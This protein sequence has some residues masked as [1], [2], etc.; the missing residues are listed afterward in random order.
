MV[1]PLTTIRLFIIRNTSDDDANTT[2]T[3]IRIT[4][5]V[6][7]E[8]LRLVLL[9]MQD[10]TFLCRKVSYAITEMLILDLFK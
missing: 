2:Y 9:A 4:L 10:G 5:A 6:Q 7:D 3:L 8:I 1:A